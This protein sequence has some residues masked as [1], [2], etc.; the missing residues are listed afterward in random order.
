M[1]DPAMLATQLQVVIYK[2]VSWDTVSLCL[3]I[4]LIQV[5]AGECDF[6]GTFTGFH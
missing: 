1:M 2:V 4:T 3:L 5:L 6:L